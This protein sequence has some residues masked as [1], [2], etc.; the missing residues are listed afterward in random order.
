M[1][2]FIKISLILIIVLNIFF[3]MW[4]VLH[5]DIFFHTD[6]ARDFLL[7]DDL[8]KRKLVLIGPRSSGPSGFYHGP[9]WMYLNYPAFLIGNGNPITVGWFWILLN[10]IF[11]TSSF[12][13][14]KKLFNSKT[15]L[16]FVALLS[17][18]PSIPDPTKNWLNG[19][20]NPFGAMFLIPF[21][22]YCIITYGRKLHKK[23]LVLALLLNGFMF[24]FQVAFGGPLLI[25]TSL[26]VIY[27]IVKKRLYSHLLAFLILL[28]PFSTYIIFDLRHNFSHVKAITNLFNDPYK[29]KIPF[30]EIVKQRLGM[31][32]MTGMHFFREPHD[33]F[34]LV[35]AYAIA[36]GIFIA[37]KVKTIKEKLP[38]QLFLYIYIGYFILSCLHNGWLM[39]YYWMPIFPLVFL[40]FA[41]LESFI[42]KIIYYTLLFVCLV[43]NMFISVNYAKQSANFI[44]KNQ[45][46]WKFESS[47]AETVFKDANGKEFGFF[48]YSPDI[49]AYS[50]KY[51]FIYQERLN[52]QTKMHIYERLP[53][54][55]LIIAPPPKDKPWMTGDWWKT[56]KIGIKQ[57]PIK[58]W[59]FDN[60]YKIEKYLLTNKDLKSPM[61]QNL[62]DWI[63]FR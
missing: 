36:F 17:L 11:L 3:P 59:D 9:A 31:L 41:S 60:G 12:I 5:N 44:G 6:I 62:N 19:Y 57:T 52:P 48:I 56:N 21:Y 61:D 58:S 27:K 20:Y 8:A 1:N 42:P 25:L 13:V 14:A 46:S 26:F 55:Y 63:Y 39:Y 4:Y 43:S 49:F 35:Y 24:Q 28:I 16:I 33:V 7:L 45:D 40:I 23:W 2:K 18:F 38:Y 32:N 37:I 34:G 10:L 47:V 29:D 51:P 22:F 54:T 30:L 53:L 50:S 15:A